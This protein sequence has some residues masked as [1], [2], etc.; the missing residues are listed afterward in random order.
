MFMYCFDKSIE[1]ELIKDGFKVVEAKEDYTIFAYDPNLK[2]KFDDV[3][4][5]KLYFTK[6]LTF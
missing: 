2:F 4:K 5:D 6:R 1:K 3:G